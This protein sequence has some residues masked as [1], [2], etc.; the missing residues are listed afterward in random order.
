MVEKAGNIGA[1]CG[2]KKLHKCRHTRKQKGFSLVLGLGKESKMIGGGCLRPLCYET[3]A[4]R[5]VCVCRR[6][7]LRLICL[8][9]RTLWMYRKFPV[10]WEL[11]K[12]Y[13]CEWCCPLHF[14]YVLFH[15]TSLTV[16]RSYNKSKQEY[17]FPTFKVEPQPNIILFWIECWWY[18]T[19]TYLTLLQIKVAVDQQHWDAT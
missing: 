8:T 13:K 16:N 5:L 10:L 14:T 3:Q 18:I 7:E 2:V 9:Q 1:R 19:K 12:L 15:W 17:W 11:S 4:R 6:M